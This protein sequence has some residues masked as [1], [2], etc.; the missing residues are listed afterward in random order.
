MQSKQYNPQP[1]AFVFVVATTIGLTST[2]L[3]S[4]QEVERKKS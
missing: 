4:I 3:Q 2:T 1:P